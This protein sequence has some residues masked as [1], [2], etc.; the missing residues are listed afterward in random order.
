M[1][2]FFED[3]DFISH[4]F[5]VFLLFPFLLDRFYGH[6]LARE[7]TARFVDVAVCALTDQGNDVIIFL[8]VL[9][10]DQL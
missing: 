10:H 5:Y 4:D 1:L 3:F 9:G 8:L 6:E 7:L 2:E